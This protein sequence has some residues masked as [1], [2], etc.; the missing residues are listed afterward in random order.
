MFIEVVEE[1]SVSDLTYCFL[2]MRKS[3]TNKNRY[4]GHN[5]RLID[6]IDH[7]NKLQVKE[8]V[9]FANSKRLLIG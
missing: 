2:S 6:I 4:M 9:F 1:S 3:N 5:I 8:V 7:F